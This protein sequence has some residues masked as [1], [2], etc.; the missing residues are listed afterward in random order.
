MQHSRQTDRRQ[1]LRLAGMACSLGGLGVAVRGEDPPGRNGGVTG[2]HSVSLHAGKAGIFLRPGRGTRDSRVDIM[3]QHPHLDAVVLNVWWREVEPQPGRYDFTE[4]KKQVKA[5]Q[6]GGKGVVIGLG[7]YGQARDDAQTPPWVYGQLDVRE[8]RFKGGGMAR[9]R[10]I[11]IPI[12]WDDGFVERYVEPMVKAFAVEFDGHPGVWY[13]QPGFGH[14]GNITCQP[15]AGGSVACLEAGWTA[16]KWLEYCRRVM[17]VYRQHF[18]KT[19]IFVKSAGMFI[20]P[21]NKY[22]DQCGRLLAEFGNQGACVIHFGLESDRAQ[23]TEVYAHLTELLPETLR[24]TSR[25]GL[26]DDWPLWV[27]EDRRE[28]SPTRNH[29]EANLRRTLENAFGGID[30]VP[31]FPI[32]VLF[33]QQPELLASHPQHDDYR[34]EVADA[35][36]KARRRLLENDHRFAVTAGVR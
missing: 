21:A 25:I 14:I 2:P 24:G 22:A 15:S 12:V 4:F 9:G 32:T 18:R 31:E 1:F 26:G 35:L 5:W 34:P 27:P 7:L 16:D 6:N 3:A 29:D 36:A 19:P 23:M 13:V 17:A 30:G 20:R 28:Q 8:L 11:R 33:C 10:E